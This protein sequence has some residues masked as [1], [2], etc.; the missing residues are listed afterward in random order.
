MTSN[1]KSNI[2][3]V[4]ALLRMAAGAEFGSEPPAGLAALGMARWRSRQ[5]KRALFVRS[6]SAV[7]VVA[8]ISIW[9]GLNSAKRPIVDPVRPWTRHQ[10]ALDVKDHP[11]HSGGSAGAGGNVKST[12]GYTSAHKAAGNPD[13]RITKGPVRKPKREEV[14]VHRRRPPHTV[15]QVATVHHYETELVTPAVLTAD[16]RQND[17]VLVEPAVIR[18]PLETGDAIPEGQN[19]WRFKPINRIAI[20]ETNE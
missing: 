8:L 10:I 9:A 2:Q 3:P 13:P 14:R 16:D 6:G 20:K 17:A 4:D 15:W 5:R 1:D 18:I 7:G 12:S 19:T 11:V